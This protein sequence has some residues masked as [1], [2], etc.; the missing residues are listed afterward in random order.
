MGSRMQDQVKRLM[1][2]ASIGRSKRQL[3]V[4]CAVF[5][6][7]CSFGCFT[8]F[9]KV[10]LMYGHLTLESLF[11]L[12]APFCASRKAQGSMPSPEALRLGGGGKS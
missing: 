12:H 6:K 4:S 8:G 10:C 5:R 11:A 1:G 3:E 7:S 9:Q 2:P